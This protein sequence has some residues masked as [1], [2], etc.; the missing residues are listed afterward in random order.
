[1]INLCAD[2]GHVDP[3]SGELLAHTPLPRLLQY[4]K[5]IAR[6]K[7]AENE[8]GFI[9]SMRAKCLALVNERNA[10]ERAAS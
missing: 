4:S 6:N 9:D 5:A 1:M 3:M 2:M 8:Y 10:A 7:G